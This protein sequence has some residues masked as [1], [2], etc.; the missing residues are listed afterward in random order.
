M[1]NG[2][3]FEMVKPGPSRDEV[4]AALPEASLRDEFDRLVADYDDASKELVGGQSPSYVVLADLIQ[5]GWKKIPEGQEPTL[6][7]PL[8][9]GNAVG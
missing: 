5:R 3:D 2:E 9:A 1:A 4:R 7:Y 6:G 8:Q